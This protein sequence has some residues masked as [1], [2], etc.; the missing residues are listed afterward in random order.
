[1][2]EVLSIMKFLLLLIILFFNTFC[3]SANAFTLYK[4]L[5]PKVQDPIYVKIRNTMDAELTKKSLLEKI[6]KNCKP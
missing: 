1:M 4:N 3:Y 2:K 5:A 6:T